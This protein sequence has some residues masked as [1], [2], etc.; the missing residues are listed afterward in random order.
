MDGCNASCNFCPKHSCITAIIQLNVKWHI[1]IPGVA[2]YDKMDTGDVC[3]SYIIATLIVLIITIISSTFPSNYTVGMFAYGYSS[4]SPLEPFGSFKN[5]TDNNNSIVSSSAHSHNA[6]TILSTYNTT[7]MVS[8]LGEVNVSDLQR[9]SFKP[10]IGISSEDSYLTKDFGAYKAAKNQSEIIKPSTKVFE[11]KPPRSSDFGTSPGISLH[12]EQQHPVSPRTN[13]LNTSALVLA[14]FEGLAQNCCFPP[15]VQLAAGTQY[16]VEMVNLDGAI[17]TKNGTLLKSF[18]LEF[19]FNPNAVKDSQGPDVSMSDPV[20]LFDNAS[21]RWFASISDISA[22][23]IRV[24]VSKTDNPIGV[25]RI[26]NFPFGLQLNN[27]NNNCSDQPFIGLSEDKFV[28]TVNNWGNDCNWSSDN[29]QPPEFRGVQF[30]I[31]DKTDLLSESGWFV[32]SVQSEPDL[33]YF[34]LHP[35]IS[36]SRTTTLLIATAGDFNHNNVQVFYIDGPLYNLHIKLISYPIQDTHVAP[37]GIQPVAQPTRQQLIS[38]EEKP[39]VSTGDARIQSAIW[40]HGKLWVAINDACFIPGDI[41]SRSCIRL[42]QTDT[43][44]NK[45]IQDFDIGAVASSLYYP[46]VSISR[47]NGGNLGVI[48]GYSSHTAFPGILVSTRSSDDKLNSIKEQLQS[49]KLGTANELSNRYGDYFAASS[50]PSNGSTIWV[51]GEYHSTATW[52][53]YIGELRTGTIGL[54]QK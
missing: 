20:L 18:G 1:K 47:G 39:K 23:S 25:W 27:N 12:G 50:D 54:S 49:L 11:V 6:A 24:A 8:Y 3:C 43:I 4:T 15:D 16:V 41:K 26:Y 14:R 13:Y 36:L 32:R 35:V 5:S 53:T 52:S 21:G 10:F 29:Q 30:T 44:T 51:A 33:S 34:S 9:P 28:V 40:S 45:V 17:Y 37:D 7:D 48:F 19:L 31:A 38:T 2:Y 42:I 46:A 22:H